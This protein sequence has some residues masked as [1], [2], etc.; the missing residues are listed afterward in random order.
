M[1]PLTSYF[2]L[3]QNVEESVEKAVVTAVEAQLGTTA[4]CTPRGASPRNHGSISPANGSE[5]QQ[6]MRVDS[7]GR[8]E[9]QG[10]S[11]V[12]GSVS[13][14]ARRVLVRPYLGLDSLIESEQVQ[15]IS[16]G[17]SPGVPHDMERAASFA[18]LAG[19]SYGTER[20]VSH[21]VRCASL[22]RAVLCTTDLDWNSFLARLQVYSMP[23]LCNYNKSTHGKI[24]RLSSTQICACGYQVVLEGLDAY[25][26]TGSSSYFNPFL[27]RC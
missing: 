12:P 15:V 10:W 17:T 18:S 23:D 20:G 26:H 2:T 21:T 5:A 6:Q 13:A 24:L 8:T 1:G 16:T 19:T 14:P 22:P 3:L 27:P 9:E 25:Q 11:A 4:S 7:T